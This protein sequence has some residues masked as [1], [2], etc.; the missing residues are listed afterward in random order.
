[1]YTPTSKPEN[2]AVSLYTLFWVIE[3]SAVVQLLSHF[4]LF[5]TPQTAVSQTSL[6][7]TI[8]WSFLKLMSIEFMVCWWW[9]E[10]CPSNHLIQLDD[11][12][13]IQSS[14][15][16]SPP[17]P[18]AFNLSQH[19]GLFRCVSSSHQ[20]AKVLAS[21]LP[22]NIQGWFPLGWTGFISL[23]SKAFPALQLESISSLALSHIIR[24]HL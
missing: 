12:M 5:V 6:S 3:C 15:P 19:Q 2:S 20:V 24:T 14:H 16:L 10:R 13:S 22:V 17:F 4:Q 23:L 1:M 11:E 18:A 9:D 8:S 21:V 7:F